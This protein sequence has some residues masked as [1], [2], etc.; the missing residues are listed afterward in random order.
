[1]RYVAVG[2]GLRLTGGSH[3]RHLAHPSALQHD[4]FGARMTEIESVLDYRHHL[5]RHVYA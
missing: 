1:M 4:K 5:A 3:L 2:T